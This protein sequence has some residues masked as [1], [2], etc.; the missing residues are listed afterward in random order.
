MLGSNV[1]A[2]KTYVTKLTHAVMRASISF[3]KPDI[4]IQSHGSIFLHQMVRNGPGAIA[5][6]GQSREIA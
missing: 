3:V 4:R 5:A 2:K 1:P 6:M